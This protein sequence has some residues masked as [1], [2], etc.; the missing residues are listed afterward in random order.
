MNGVGWC[1][2]LICILQSGAG[3]GLVVETEGSS[4][5]LGVIAWVTGSLVLSAVSCL[6]RFVVLFSQSSVAELWGVVLALQCSSAIHLGVDNLNVVR[7]V[8]RILDGRVTCSAL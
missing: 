2:W 4:L 1:R 3:D 6:T 7:H 5:C 8:S